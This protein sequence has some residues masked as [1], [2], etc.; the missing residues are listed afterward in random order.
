MNKMKNRFVLFVLLFINVSCLAMIQPKDS[1]CICVTKGMSED[2]IISWAHSGKFSELPDEVAFN[3]ISYLG[4]DDA[5]VLAQTCKRL[6]S[7]VKSF[8]KNLLVQKADHCIIS[9]NEESRLL[10]NRNIRNNV[11]L[12]Q[13][14]KD[15]CWKMFYCAGICFVFG[16]N[17]LIFISIYTVGVDSSHQE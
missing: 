5:K 11:S 16:M 2:E 17:T 13:Q 10:N 8:P 4:Y 3:I 12:H 14:V 7:I 6:S 9:I 1:D 15:C